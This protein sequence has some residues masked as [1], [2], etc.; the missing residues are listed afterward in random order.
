ML[1]NLSQSDLWYSSVNLKNRSLN[2]LI[3]YYNTYLSATP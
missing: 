2:Y 3:L 1:L